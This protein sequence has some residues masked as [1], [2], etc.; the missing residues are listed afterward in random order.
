MTRRIVPLI[1]LLA[2]PLLYVMVVLAGGAPRFP[3]RGECIRP[4]RAD[5]PIE[6]VFGRF[7]DRAA[8]TR[9]LRRVLDV[10]FKESHLLGDG[11]GFLR[12]AVE[13]IPSLAVGRDLIAEAR[14]V[15]LN[16]TLEQGGP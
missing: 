10:G 4:A 6:A 14:A 2:A 13:Q 16:P 3:T 7:R 12:V 1:L 8:A 9:Q 5:R 11:C 15:G